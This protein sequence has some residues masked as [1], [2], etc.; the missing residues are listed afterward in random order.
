MKNTQKVE[1]VRV[2]KGVLCSSCNAVVIFATAVTYMLLPV[3]QVN[4]D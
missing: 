2:M 3:F 1:V 4:L